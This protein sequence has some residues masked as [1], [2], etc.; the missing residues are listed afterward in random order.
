M[1]EFQTPDTLAYLILGLSVSLGAM[2]LYIVSLLAKYRNLQKDEATID[3][4]RN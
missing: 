1:P 2:A 3:Q 4:A